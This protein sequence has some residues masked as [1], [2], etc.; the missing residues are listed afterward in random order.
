MVL[1]TWFWFVKQF[2]SIT[3]L[4]CIQDIFFFFQS[5]FTLCILGE[6]LLWWQR[7]VSIYPICFSGLDN[8]LF[9]EIK[10]LAAAV[11]CTIQHSESTVNAAK[12]PTPLGNSG[13]FKHHSHRPWLLLNPQVI[14]SILPSHTDDFCFYCGIN[15][16]KTSA[17]PVTHFR[18]CTVFLILWHVKCYDNL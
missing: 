8:L 12:Y 18:A 10:D 2:A 16:K 6:H 1:Q 14:Q 7:M 9:W 15:Q 3:G 5:T 4:E 13:R 17:K 11:S